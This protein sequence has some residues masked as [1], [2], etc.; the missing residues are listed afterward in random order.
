MGHKFSKNQTQTGL[1]SS[2][3]RV[4]ACDYK[5]G[6]PVAEGTRHVYPELVALRDYFEG[7]TFTVTNEKL[8]AGG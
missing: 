1:T 5:P 3:W 6:N 7:S 2:L 4:R 8:S